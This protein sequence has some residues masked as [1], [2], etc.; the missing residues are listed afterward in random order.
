MS[1]TREELLFGLAL[2]KSVP[3][4]PAFLDRECA[5]DPALRKR[6]ENLLAAHDATDIIDPFAA[7]AARGTIKLEFAEESPDEAIGQT[8][9]RYKLLEMVGEGGC[10]VVY[11]AEQTEPV[12]RRVALKVIKLGMDTKDVVAR[13]GAE[14]QALAMMDHPNIA[15]VLDAGTT[16]KGRPY[17]VMELV[18]GIRITDYCD[19]VNLSTKE[20]LALFIKVCQAIQHAHQKGIIH[21]DIKPS[22]ILVTLHDGVPVPKVIDFGIAKATEGRLTASTVY[23]QLH[24]FMGTPAYMSP[25]QAEMSGLDIDT[26]SDIYSLGVLLYELLVGIP[27]FD[28][29]ELMAQGLD[30]MRKT[31]RDKEPLRPSTKLGA[32]RGEDL[33][34]TA[35]HRSVQ[36]SKLEHLLQGDLDWIVMKCLEKDRGR[37]YDTANGLAMDIT[38]H[39][40]D[41]AVVARPPSAAYKFQKAIRRN[42][43]TYAAIG[44]IALALLL[45]AVVSASLAITATRARTDAQ[46]AEWEQS[47]LRQVADASSAREKQLRALAVQKELETR[48]NLY[49][50]DMLAAN[51]AL[52]E[53][54]LGY[55]TRLLER[56]IPKTAAGITNTDEA[57]P[58]LRGWEWRHLMKKSRSQ[59]LFSFGVMAA[60]ID[61]LACSPDGRFLAMLDEDQVV[62]MMD[63]EKRHQLAEFKGIP[64]QLLTN[65]WDRQAQ[66]RFSAD[67][68]S[69]A[70]SVGKC[71][72]FLQAP[73]LSASSARLLCLTNPI[74]HADFLDDSGKLAIICSGEKFTWEPA[75]GNITSR[76]PFP[77]AEIVLPFPG[78]QRFGIYWFDWYETNKYVGKFAIWDGSATPLQGAINHSIWGLRKG[79]ALSPNGSFRAESKGSHVQVVKV[80][81]PTGVTPL[82]SFTNELGYCVASEFSPDSSILACGWSDQTLRLYSAKSWTEIA[83]LRGHRDEVRTVAFSSDGHTVF[84]GSKDGE[85]KAWA[86]TNSLSG[87]AILHLNR[88]EHPLEGVSQNCLKGLRQREDG[89]IRIWNILEPDHFVDTLLP[90]DRKASAHFSP[91]LECIVW[92]NSDGNLIFSSWPPSSP[93]IALDKI[94][95]PL[96]LYCISADTRW[97]AALT[98][99]NELV[100][101]SAN[102][103]RLLARQRMASLTQNIPTS[104]LIVS[105]QGVIAGFI[106]GNG[107]LWH[108]RDSKAQIT[109]LEKV[110][111]GFTGIALSPDGG[112]LATSGNDAMIRCWN[113][114]TGKLVKTLDG[115]PNAFK[116]VAFSPDGSRLLGC[117]YHSGIFI[118]DAHDFRLLSILKG[119]RQPI[120]SAS[121]TPDNLHLVSLDTSELIIWTADTP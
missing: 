80:L 40:T 19:Q 33:T 49:A 78:A 45:G 98:A 79:I 104:S 72:L 8:L 47:R 39:L 41:E 91:N 31:I 1:L 88:S 90:A 57:S 114:Q 27:P 3:E 77:K 46:K 36:T 113:A 108:A 95:S 89:T 10:G 74:L 93:D 23:T 6:V 71:A 44:G 92:A 29:R 52:A 56:Y 7:A 99:A 97:V 121:L 51:Q 35:K 5:N 109:S 64:E 69:L 66:I 84:T 110:R 54:R 59:K 116:G 25:E 11:V 86:V 65:G 2:T 102:T 55:A 20:R 32:M 22:N 17:F 70:I 4:R 42:K 85:V 50:S 48:K 96:I 82:V 107:F 115:D 53:N 75:A 67:G 12:R 26:R 43:L 21:R 24:Q 106:A 38:R 18:R 9:G 63:I 119:H 120:F 83:V 117:G 101:W 28:P 105:D 94:F 103:G 37:R 100:L 73:N 76:Q 34:T 118:W 15:K 14:R 58:H 112:V 16:D 61:S 68:A 111:F 87:D 13:F 62:R 81:H 30:A 60:T